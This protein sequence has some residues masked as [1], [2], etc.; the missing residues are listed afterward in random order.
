MVLAQP[1]EGT[2]GANAFEGGVQPQGDAQAWVD[3]GVAWAT[4]AGTDVVVQASEVEA[5]TEI[6]DDAGLVVAIEELI[7][8]H[9]S[10]DVLAIS[11]TQ[12]RGR[13][14]T[15]ERFLYAAA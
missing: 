10:E 7:E 13:L 3:S 6:P 15:H 14:I 2:G 12:T 1:G 4:V 11:Q 8:R 5:E 9:R